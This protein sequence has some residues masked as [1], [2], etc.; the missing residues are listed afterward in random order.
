MG[1]HKWLSRCNGF[2]GMDRNTNPISVYL[3]HSGDRFSKGSKSQFTPFIWVLRFQF[4]SFTRVLRFQFTSF[5]R[6]RFQFTSFTRV[7][8][9]QFTSFT[10]VLRFQF[11]SFT[12]LTHWDFSLPHSRESPDFSLPHSLRVSR[13]QFT[14]FTR[15][16]FQFSRFQFTSFTRLIFQFYIIHAHTKFAQLLRKQYNNSVIT[17]FSF[18]DFNRWM[19][20]DQLTLLA[21]CQSS[22][23]TDPKQR[24]F[25]GDLRRRFTFGPFWTLTPMGMRPKYQ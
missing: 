4:T 25:P 9:F 7:S 3:I 6:L 23:A 10:R 13:F 8:R 21:A 5:T 22:N 1:N 12:R 16:R 15:Q 2:G 20:V 19:W 17:S 18:F 14:S 11:T 24:G